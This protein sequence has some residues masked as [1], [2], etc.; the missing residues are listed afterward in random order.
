[1]RPPIR[2]GCA[3]K[4]IRLPAAAPR[5]VTAQ[6]YARRGRD[7]SDADGEVR[8]EPPLHAAGDRRELVDRPVVAEDEVGRQRG[9][10][11]VARTPRVQARRVHLPGGRP[12]RPG[13]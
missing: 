6:T 5:L 1:T 4:K 10:G 3:T 2:P 13:P 9:P 8:D 12:R 11:E 7:P